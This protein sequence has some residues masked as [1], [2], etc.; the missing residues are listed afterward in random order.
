MFQKASREKLRFDTGKGQLSVEDLWDLPLTSTTGRPNLDSIAQELN[1]QLKTSDTV[2]FV[3]PSKKT[4]NT[5]QLKFDIVKHIIDVRL[6][7]NNARL[8][9]TEKAERKEKLRKLIN[10]KEEEDLQGKTR[11]E[12]IAMLDEE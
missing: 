1:K 10:A 9:A 8:Q 5:V 6:A 11:E 3:N 12:L 7:E 4:N 2:S